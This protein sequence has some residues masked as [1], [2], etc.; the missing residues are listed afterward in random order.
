ME[1]LKCP[2]KWRKNFSW[3]NVPGFIIIHHALHNDCNIQDV[4]QWHLDQW[5]NEPGFGYHYFI[6]QIGVIIEGRDK[7]AIG[8]H[9]KGVNKKSLGIC[10]EG[11]YTDYGKITQKIVPKKQLDS[12]VWLCQSLGLPI[13][14]HRD[15]TNEKDCPGKYFIGQDDLRGKIKGFNLNDL[16]HKVFIKGYISSEKY[17]K[18]KC[19]KD[20]DILQLFKNISLK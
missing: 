4:H 12:L 7:K 20:V 8:A 1:I 16:V 18:E 10:L 17:W 5:K 6:N 9:T 11:C 15:F 3:G 19:L 13:F 14:Y 2:L